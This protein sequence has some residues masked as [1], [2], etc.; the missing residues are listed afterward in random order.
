MYRIP[1]PD[2]LAAVGHALQGMGVLWPWVAPALVSG[3]FPVFKS[4]QAPAP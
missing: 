1:E 2:E 4:I 3:A